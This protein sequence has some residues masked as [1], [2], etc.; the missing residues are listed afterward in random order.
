MTTTVTDETSATDEV[1][2]GEVLPAIPGKLSLSEAKA[3]TKKIETASSKVNKSLGVAQENFDALLRL[4]DEAATGKAHEI[5]G[6]SSWTAYLKDRVRLEVPRNERLALVSAM[7]EK[8][9]SQRAIASVLKVS[10]KTVQNDQNGQ[11]DTE[12][13][14]E[15][16]GTDGKSQ[17]RKKQPNVVAPEQQRPA[18]KSSETET[19][20]ELAKAFAD[21]MDLLVNAVESFMDITGRIMDADQYSQA[22]SRIAKAQRDRMNHCISKLEVIADQLAEVDG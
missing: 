22:R 20:A 16:L 9:M 2:E 3:L 8:G 10:K 21:E 14:R 12:Y 1:L 18:E 13:P 5:L 17:P 7:T 6:Y 4:L 19:P 11:V 15:V